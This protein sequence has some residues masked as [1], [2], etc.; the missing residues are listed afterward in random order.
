VTSIR[1]RKIP[2]GAAGLVL[3]KAAF[4]DLMVWLISLG[5][6]RVFREK[7]LRPAHLVRGESVLDVGCG[8][9]SLAIAAKH[10]VGS[11]GRVVGVD[12]SASMLARAKRKAEKSRLDIT[13]K[14]AAAQA[15]PFPDAQFD[16][17]CS[18]LML[19]HLPRKD[20]ATSV[21]EMARVLRH[22][23]RVL[24]VEFAPPA[25][26]GTRRAL[27][28][29]FHR[30]GHVK[31]EH[32]LALLED[33]GLKVTDSGAIGRNLHFALATKICTG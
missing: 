17:V 8:T 30:H 4:Y 21:R 27:L 19:H 2:H 31:L 11:D 9:G 6:E 32:I 16:V 23:G 24:V 18:S 20:R 28:P 14:Q 22:G 7:L 13:F 26:Q 25:Q 3:H 33:A 12:A 1:D 29:G 15:L 10:Q 5:R